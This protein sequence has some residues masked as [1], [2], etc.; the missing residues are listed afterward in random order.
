MNAILKG[1]E[2]EILQ[3]AAFWELQ[4]FFPNTKVH[5]QFIGPAIPEHRSVVYLK[6]KFLN[7]V[8]LVTV[9][10]LHINLTGLAS[11]H[12]MSSPLKHCNGLSG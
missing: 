9:G 5:I 10:T 11:F 4:A 7:I 8:F 6:I 2:K 3:L 1:P 12:S